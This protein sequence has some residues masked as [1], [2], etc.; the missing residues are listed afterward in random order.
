MRS[1]PA[2]ASLTCVPIDEIWT[3]G[4]ATSAFDAFNDHV[5]T[6]VTDQAHS[7]V[8]NL[9]AD[10][11][12]GVHAGLDALTNAGVP[13]VAGLDDP[14]LH[15]DGPVIDEPA[16]D[17]HVDDDWSHAAPEEHHLDADNPGFDI[18]DT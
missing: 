10:P 16:L 7:L 15:F 14:S 11:D 4:A 2:N 18:F 9:V 5:P 17:T 12:P 6:V 3:S 13:D 1:R 8:A